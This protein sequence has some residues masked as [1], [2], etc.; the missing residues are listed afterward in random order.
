[1]LAADETARHAVVDGGEETA[2]VGRHHLPLQ[3][4]GEAGC[5]LCLQSLLPPLRSVLLPG[6]LEDELD[7][8]S[9]PDAGIR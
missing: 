1:M 8:F 3:A 4:G 6:G 7:G 9:R 5:L 2:V